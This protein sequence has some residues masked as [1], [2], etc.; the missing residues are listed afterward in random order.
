MPVTLMNLLALEQRRQVRTS[1]VND[2]VEDGLDA[3]N[4]GAPVEEV[5]ELLQHAANKLA[6]VGETLTPSPRKIGD[7]YYGTD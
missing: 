2:V 1:I 6:Q 4:D 5:I 7:Y 3:L